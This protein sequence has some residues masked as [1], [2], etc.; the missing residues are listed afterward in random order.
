MRLDL[1]NIYK[2]IKEETGDN[3]I[4][5]YL[6]KTGSGKTV[7]QNEEHVIP[8]LLEGLEVKCCYWINYDTRKYKNLE[9]FAPKDFDKIKN[10]RNSI[11]VFDEIRRSFDPRG[12]QMESEELRGFVELHR[13]RHNT[14]IFNTQDISLVAKTFGI[15]THN[16]SYL[17]K[18]NIGL[19]KNMWD[20]IWEDRKIRIWESLL[21]YQEL[22]KMANGWEL[23]E[24][25]GLNSHTRKIKYSFKRLLHHELDEY[26]IELIHRYCPKCNSRQGE[27]ILKE[28][29][30][31]EAEEIK[32]GI[33]KP[34]KK[35]YCPK[36]NEETKNPVILE[37]RESGMFDTDYE[38]VESKEQFRIVKYKMCKECG[39]EHIV[40]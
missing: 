6:G 26:K 8:A 34:K 17:E 35:I 19:I 25:V 23:G 1:I 40:N 18:D 32:E 5:G 15:Q 39:K 3:E 28:D 36:H 27:Q 31:K 38:P 13:H 9:Y 21:S 20:R 37:I 4:F 11:I 12:Y 10:V 2:E 16:W 33:W 14:I 22:K 7:I 30:Y 24:D 29:T